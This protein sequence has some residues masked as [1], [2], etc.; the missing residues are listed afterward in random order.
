MS[1]SANN[2]WD[3][4]SA[5]DWAR[6]FGFVASKLFPPNAMHA[7]TDGSVLR[8]GRQLSF[9]LLGVTAP[10][11]DREALS[12]SW[13]AHTRYLL[14]PR[15]EAGTLVIHRWDQPSAPFQE[16]SL[17]G[18]KSRPAQ[19]ID[20]LRRDRP[21]RE[22][23]AVD[24]VIQ[25]FRSLRSRVT[26]SEIAI[27]LLHYLLRPEDEHVPALRADAWPSADVVGL[28]DRLL[29]GNERLGLPLH[30]ELLLRHA[31]A[32]LFQEAHVEADRQIYSGQSHLS[33]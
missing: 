18:V 27:R 2:G 31:A 33:M 30:P 4:T 28:R 23:D 16:L 26:D 6:R 12:W 21:P 22:Q 8:D 15:V 10:H 24:H 7:P 17:D 1:Q 3:P 9:T 20:L 5:E 29:G 19:V 13:S 11:Q 14:R 32:E 25:V